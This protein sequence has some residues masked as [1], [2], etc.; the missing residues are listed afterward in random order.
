MPYEKVYKRG[1]RRKSGCFM[2]NVCDLRNFSVDLVISKG[3]AFVPGS[4]IGKGATLYWN[5]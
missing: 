1:S 4:G 2:S 5:F 3:N